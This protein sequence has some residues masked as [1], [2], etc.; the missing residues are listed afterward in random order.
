MADGALAGPCDPP[1]NEIV[2]EN[3]KPGNP[4]SE[5]DVEG[6]GDPSIQGFATE[7]SVDR[8][9][10]VHFKVDT[11]S[12]EY[13]LDVYRMGY[14]GG[15]G[16]RKVDTVEPS[17]ALPQKQPGCD[18]KPSTGLVDCGN[19]AESASWA[20]PADAVSGIYFAKL[21]REDQPSD[22]SQILFVV[23]DDGGG[24][25]LLFQT[26]DTTW[27][28]YNR[29][30]G[31][32]LYVGGPGANPGRAY[33]VS[34]NRPLTTRGTAPEDAP[35]SAEYPMVR[36][37]ER[38]GYDVS[39]FTGVDADRRG[40][41]ILDHEAYLSVGHDEYW[42]GAQRANVEAARDAGV[43]L[44]FF[45]GNEIFWK[46]RWED[47]IDG[48]GADHRTLV[49]YKETHANAKIDPEANVWTGTWRD[50]R[51]SP[52]ADGGKPENSLSGTIF[53]VD[54]GT[55]AI[56][57]P[58]ADGRLR[59]WRD[60]GIASLGPG[61]TA[62]LGED[63]LGYEWD[64]DVD[65]GF[66]PPGLMDLS[67]T[68]VEVP[69][70]LVDYGSN[71]APG[72]GTHHLTLYR[73]PNGA[74]VFGA[75]TVQWSWGLDG[76]HD[77]GNTKPDSRMQQ[78]TVNLLADMGV[79]AGSL[80]GGLFAAT[81]TTDADPP[82]SAIGSPGEGA[83]LESGE[84]VTIG[85][86]ATD[87]SGET[88]GGQ[89][90]GIEVS[91]DGGQHWHPADGRDQWTYAWT[92]GA[93]GK[94]T[95]EARA[96][97]DSG[98]LE[99]AGDQ[100]GVEVTPPTCPCSIWDE[101]LAAPEDDDPAGAVE[102]GVKFR[103]DVAGLI[104]GVRFYKTA[105]NVGQHVGRL[106]T[107][108]GA[109]LAQAAFTGESASGW[110]TV[111]FDQ[112]VSI[113]AGKTYIAS[114]HAPS[115]HY[116]GLS[117]YFALVGHDN[118]PLHALADG[119]DG[120]N[121]VFQYGPAGGLFTEGPPRSFHSTNYLVDVVFDEHVG[122]DTTP[123]SLNGQVPADGTTDIGVNVAA[124]A[125]FSEAMN[126]ATISSGTI[127]LRD[128][129]GGLVESAVS[130]SPGNRRAAVKSI[131]PLHYATTYTATVKGGAAGVK[132]LAGNALPSSSS[133]SFTT[134]VAP[135]PPPD[136][137]P[138]GPILVISNAANPFSRYYGEILRAEGLNEF[139][140]KDISTV[141][142]A[143]LDAY[144][145]AILGETTL[146]SGQAQMLE[147]WVGGGGNLIAM[148][149][150]PQLSGLLGLNP[151]GGAL[152]NA[153][154]KVD[155]GTAP[156][157]GIV[158]Q[159]IQFHG[160][161]DRYTPTSAQTI[162]TLYSS[163][164]S[165]T[166]NPAVTLRSVGGKGGQ[167]ASFS[168]DLARSVVL[169]RQGN[170]AWSGEER[171]GR[172]PIRSD[173][174]FFGNKAG[175]PQPD[176]VDLEKVAI[177]QADEQQRLL[178]NLIEKMNA[179]RK[180]LPRFWFLPRDE[181][182]AVV[183]T[184]DD[185]GN[186]GTAGRFDGYEKA[187]PPG[188]VVAK[189]ECVR[190]TSYIYPGTPLTDA[191]AS[192]YAS[193]GFE[194]SLHTLTNCGDWD[195]QGELNAFFSSQL[196]EFSANFPS[197]PAPATNRTHCV[198]WGDWATQPKVERANGIRL[199]ANYY[200][201]PA[202]W[203]Q[204][205]PGMFTGS[206]MPMRF[207]DLDGSL[208]D[209]YQ[210]ATQMTDESEQSYP[211]TA[212]TLLDNALG[213]KGYYGVF[214][215]N[216]HT[217]V[218]EIE[219]SDAIVASAQ[220]R[221]VPVVSARQMLTWLD[222]RNQSSFGSIGWTGN[223]LSFTISPGE[224]ANGLRAM[225]PVSPAAGDLLSV[226]R[227][228]TPV[229]T[230]IQTIKG[231]EYAFFDATAGSYTAVYGPEL[232][233]T[234]PASPANANS[235]K[236]TGSAPSG[237]TVR[238]YTT[239]D[240][241]GSPLAT[242]SAA[243]L[244]GGI[245]VSV[246][247]DT[248][249][250]FR[251]T[252]T[253]ANGSVSP[254]SAPLAYVEDSSAPDA[255][256]GSH[257]ANPVASAAASFAFS[258]SDGS[259]SGVASFQ[260]RRDSEAAGGWQ[261]C[262][263]PQAYTGLADG[264]H[265]FEVRAIDQAGNVDQSPAVFSWTVDTVAPQTQI[266]L[267][268]PALSATGNAE[269]KFS[270]AD[271][272]GSGVAS[273]QC[274]LDSS[275][276]SGWG[277]CT[278]PQV[279]SSLADGA[280]K[281]EVRAID[282]AGN[283]DQSPAVFSW[284]V[285]VAPPDTQIGK[286]PNA[287]VASSAAQF[288]FSG[289]DGSGSGV[290]SFQCRLDSSE[291]S[292]WGACTSPQVY[293]SLADGSHKFEVRAVD[294]AGNVDPTPALFSW[295][296]DM[297]APQT[298]TAGPPSLSASDNAQFEF[299][300][301]DG[302]GSGVSSFQCRLDSLEASAWGTCSSPKEYATLADGSHKFEVRAIDVVGNVDQSPA[303]LSWTVDTTAPQ[304]Q[305][306]N[307]PPLISASAAATLIFSGADGAGS[308]VASFE[309]RLDSTAPSGWQACASP[310]EY[311]ALADGV[312]KF[313][314]RAIDVAGN[315]DPS[316]A[317]VNWTVDTT[318]PDTQIDDHPAA[319][320]AT[321]SAQFAFSG[322]DG[323]GSGVAAFQCRLDSSQAG[324]W[325][326]C[327]SPKSYGGL[328]DGGHKLEVRAIDQAGNV[329]S[330]AA[331]FEWNVDTTAPQTQVDSGPPA[332]SALAVAKFAFSG[333]DGA[334]SGVASL[335]C[336]RD[337][338][339]P[340]GWGPC[341]SPLE[342]ASLGDGGHKFEVRA[343][344]MAGNVD[345]TPAVFNW[346]IDTTSPDT[347]IG[348]H[349]NALVASSAAQFEF[350]GSDGS[351]S[352]VASFQCRLDSSEASGWAS[353]SSPQSYVS[354]GDGSHEF[355]VRAIDQA[356]N[357]DAV[358]ASF[359]WSID[360]AAPETQI[361]TGPPALSASAKAKFN[362]SGADGAGS[363][364]ASFE[365]R[366]DSTAPSAW[367]ACTS[368]KEYAALADGSHKLEVRA[369]DQIGNVDLTPAV[370]NWTVDTTAPESQIDTHPSP[371]SASAEAKFTFSGSDA[372][373]SG[374]A[375]FECRRDSNEASAWEAC[376][377]PR[378]YAALPDG[379]HGLE[380][381]A[382]DVAGNVDPSPASFNWTIDTAAPDTQI[383]S[384]AKAL[385]GSAAA[386]FA[387]SGSDGTGSGV[388]SFQCR[389]DSTQAADWGGC[390]SPRAYG[391]LADG[392][393]KFEVR[394]IDAAGNVDQAPASFEWTVDTTP[395]QTQID[396][397]PP[398]LSGSAAAKFSFSG[399]DGSGSGVASFQCRLDSTAPSAWQACS[400]P[401]EYAA[402]ADGAH[403]LEVRAVDGAANPDPSPASF[404][405]T[406][407]TTPPAVTIDSLSRALLGIGQTSEV[408]WHANEN[409]AF[410]LR[411]GGNDCSS[412]T[413]LDSGAYGSQ[414]ATHASI[415]AVAD[416]AE[417]QNTLRLCLTDAASNRGSTTAT[418][419]RDTATPE[420]QIDSH[421]AALSASASA[422]FAFSGSDG[423][424]SGV[425]SFQ[426]RRDSSEASAWA[427]C[428][429][430]QSYAS[431]ADGTHSFEVRAVDVAGNPDPSPASF[432]WTVDTTPPSVAIDSG[433]HGLTND[434]TPSFAFHASEPGSSFECSIDSGTPDFG[435]CSD[436]GSHTPASPLT[437]GAHTFRVRA[438][439][440]ASNQG[441][442]TTREFTVDTAA[443]PAPELTLTV[444]ASPANENSPKIVGSAPAG[445]TV[446]IYASLDCSGTALATVT[447]AQLVD[448]VSVSVPDDSTTK[449]SANGTSLAGNPS[450]CSDPIAYAE[451]SSAPN[452]QI[453]GHPADPAS[454]NVATFVFSGSD[455]SGSGVASFQCRLDSTQAADWG[456]CSSPKSYSSLGD[457][458]HG[459][460][461]RAIDQAG[462]VDQSPASF[463]WTIDTAAPQTQID[464][465]PAAL[466]TSTSAQFEFSG[467]D[468]SGTGVAVFQCR[469]DSAEASAWEPCTSPRAY[470][471]LAD[472]GHGFEVRAVDGAGNVD[473]SPASFSWAVDTTGPQTQIDAHP[474]SLSP[475]T[476]AQFGFSATDPGGS[477]VSSFECRLDS[478][479]PSGWEA[480][481]S[482]VGYSSL[483][484]G[485][486]K[487]EVRAIDAAGNVDPSP[488]AFTW[489][490]DTTAPQTQIDAHPAALTASGSAQFGFSGSDSSGAT[491]FECRR[492]SAEPSAWAPC[493][494]P[495]DYSSL[496]DGSHKFEVRA[497]DAVGNVDPSTASFEWS[498]DTAAPETQIDSHPAALS[499][500][501]SASFAF[502]GSDGAGSGVGS[503]QCR[504]DSTEASAWGPC[505]SPQSYASL[506]DGA[507]VFQVRAIDLAGN[508]DP[509]PTAFGWT[510][511]TTPP[512]ATIDSGPSGLTNDSTPTF[513]FHAGEAGSSFECS[514]DSGAP[515]FGP[516]SDAGS[517]T[518]ASP[519]G[520]GVHTFRVRATDAAANQGTATIREFSVDTA[521]PS[522]P[523]LTS[524]VPASPANENSP[525]IVGSA[526]GGSTVRL[527]A[528]IDCSGPALATVSAAQLVDGVLVSVL[529]DTTTKFSANGTSL[530]GNPSG[531]S[532]PI[533]YAEDSSAPNAQIDGHPADPASSNVATF[534]FSGSDGSGS[535][536]A[537]FQ[538]RIDS[539]QAADWAACSSPESYG[540]LGEGAH[541]FE[542]RA[543]DRAGN[544]D[545]SPASFPW[546]IDTAAP[547][548]Q[549]DAHPAALTTSTSAQFEFS[550]SDGS[551][552]GVAIFQ[553]RRDSAEASAWEPC[554][555]PR[556]YASLADGPHGFEV[557]AVDG[558]G[559]VDP[560]PASF[561]WT[562]DT[563]G[564][565]TQI[566]AHPASLSPSTAAQF[567]FS[568][569][570]P[571]GSGVSS[572]EC[573]LDSTA[574]SGW[575]ACGSPVGYSSL[576]DGPHKFEV[577]AID[578]A[579]NVDPS[580][581]AFTWTVDTT[582]PQTQIDAHPAALTASGSA[583]FGFSGSDSSGATSFEC[584]RDSAEPSAWAPCS[585][586]KDY[587]SLAD[588]SHKFEVR[589]IDAV[590]NV[591]PS[592]A[593]FE[594]SVDTAAPET[595]IDSHPAALSA[596]ASASFAFSGSDGAGSGVGSFQCRRDSTEASAWGPCASPQSYASLGD[597]AHVFQVRAID[598][599]GNADPSPTA[600]GWTI[601]TTPPTA[602]IDSG[603][604]GLTN[605]STPTFAFHAGEA[606]SSFECSIDSGAPSFG[607]CSDAGSHTPASPLGDG[608]HTFRVR[609]TDAA[610][611][612][613]TATI[614]EFSVDTAAP[615][616]P[617]LTSTVPA[618]PANENS[619]KIVGSA[620]GGSTVRLYAGIDCS[621]PALATVSAAQLV[622]GV[623]VSVL[624]DTT[625]KFSA[626][627]TSLAGNPSGCSDP[628]A[629]AE[630]SS[631]P[632]AQ[633][634]GHPADP[635][636]SNVA[637]F[638]FSG[639]DGSGSGVASFQC[640]IDSGQAADWAAC[641]SPES[642]GSLG[643]GAHS[644]EVRA[645]DRAG[646]VDQSPAS[647]AWT[648][649]TV[650]PQT[651]ID[652][653]PPALT[654]S[655]SAQFEFSGSDGSGTGVAI[656]QCRRD[657]AEASAWEPCTSPRAY[658]SLADG[659]HGF[660]VRAVDGAGN[661]DPSP[662]S[663]GWT[664]DTTAPPSPELTGTVP[665]SP[666]NENSPKIVGS[667]PLGSTVRLYAN[668]DCSGAAIATAS[669]AELT[670]GVAVSVTDDSTSHFS[671]DAIASGKPSPCS[672]P[673][674]YVED[675]TAPSTQIDAHPDALSG[676]TTAQFAFSGSDGSGSGVA[677]FEC[678]RD[679]ESAA[680]WQ[681]CNSP[682]SYAAL[683]D[684]PH[685][686]QVRAIDAAGN[687]DSS[688]AV[689]G[690]TVD[691]AP[692]LVQP[693]VTAVSPEPPTSAHDVVR[694]L[695]I[696]YDRRRRAAILTIEVPGPGRLSAATPEPPVSSGLRKADGSAARQRAAHQI[697][698]KSVRT[699]KA[700]KVKLRVR[701]TPAS[702]QL[703]TEE[704]KVTI[705]VLVSFDANDGSS[706]SR[707]IA[708]ALK[709]P[710][711]RK[712]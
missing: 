425:A 79:K 543:I 510:I 119:V 42:S 580:P 233:A 44:A 706:E 686:F 454:S 346:T 460:E 136:S 680:A 299:S 522:P 267:G 527:Y 133:W 14:Y 490:V 651:Q 345:L 5:W 74:L 711:P 10:T 356:G 357:V 49:A 544:V 109:Q 517:H 381:R 703:L 524:T 366:L 216:M 11:A 293:S 653:H 142:A 245:A 530:A 152:A 373:G 654:T 457:G 560:S 92:P 413:V 234:T 657:S 455:G 213:S 694:I 451:D 298:Q 270:G 162:A 111:T 224:G 32:S 314:V 477:G 141:T 417:G 639:S 220:A 146:S 688:P 582:A 520:D 682:Q 615:S 7:I 70:R 113:E 196:G 289:S 37:L 297:T 274:R 448:G 449:F 499:A 529:D 316:P 650:A 422:S 12:D 61:E 586:P 106:W 645:I 619:P 251:A 150:D 598:L 331:S 697:V 321:P 322:A 242:G 207:A 9:E 76:E 73:A 565:Q 200:Y 328:A 674:A 246:P 602:T 266:D 386:S 534:V 271:A 557:R 664:V 115:G 472:G 264:A 618:S 291:A 603:P 84:A 610:A 668:A 695:Q 599:A 288:E 675:S 118:G 81:Q 161:A 77:R 532:D 666:A 26:S 584:R 376:A 205:R 649:D 78:A 189:W 426:C 127:E 45:S 660:E 493:S 265:K 228:G 51:F 59:L 430:P 613:G 231:I 66:R 587:S 170:P 712:Q 605:D 504:R 135:P 441:A 140:V 102:L 281:F 327:S 436:A 600:F 698:P 16:A 363:G 181:R 130:Y 188:C 630:D 285:D 681:P 601:D 663:F 2:C 661:V 466:T 498:V 631:A 480:C 330:T 305:I 406:V 72:T 122:P 468:G 307:G 581:A 283:V 555:S 562:V 315:A 243:Q 513:A 463:P 120:E 536:V 193:A 383:D 303:S 701:L 515:S 63:T 54:E 537:S 432:S 597:G 192:A 191:Q 483:V 579:G 22:G 635:A 83:Q 203:V 93:V 707:T 632:N 64:E 535:G 82:T 206:G 230:A 21:V 393:H 634:D 96:V 99:S 606:G 574:P 335:E 39:Y 107:A 583:Q 199:D 209:V 423:P 179:D 104:A 485:P 416:L 519:L 672:Q 533:A 641:S 403:K 440:A 222:G 128:G 676:S 190:S 447:P 456:P 158:D 365:C 412:G 55:A 325:A 575:E 304:T 487:F 592:T 48:S 542:V 20:V 548:T 502:S 223:R 563:T 35:F 506:G 614:R 250:E 550:G 337:S 491:S 318:A 272:T 443:P 671:A 105:G 323:S 439:D 25:D 235:L 257:P 387:F 269:F 514:I 566:D 690:W 442:S 608:V 444:P 89:V 88:A 372:G 157:A 474:A 344:D 593:S 400:S 685:A 178:T 204:D 156:G 402:L 185:H 148:R 348:K 604:S 308:G 360:T 488:A 262:T 679:S 626:N 23:R 211:F 326:P 137:G 391:S 374:L 147:S 168:Y 40:S 396:S 431:L 217:D 163:A 134:E 665:A 149:P 540:S 90:A 569:T 553:C 475:S 438:T 355:E 655:T 34:Y 296:V 561:G 633:I 492:D 647:F 4:P 29:Y 195:G 411:V 320:L 446:R 347:Q 705:R 214:G 343:I 160:S 567:G 260:C 424:G 495:K 494:S 198:A 112:P 481:G 467:S 241:S 709:Q 98:N 68:T 46:T 570:D 398:A 450:G 103:S 692:P 341:L 240:C 237:S 380:V 541:S 658:A 496:A 401:K 167:A 28:A 312:H 248:T 367:Q 358:P 294:V 124:A 286:H 670:S 125:T 349:P 578:A 435:P 696:K 371:L 623:L 212:D 324:D 571:G 389:L 677:S 484:D 612:Q 41:E 151:S 620:P 159:T 236:V 643:E 521:A 538:C 362:F 646:N 638:V 568:A 276:A 453:D 710:L 292:G 300:G 539:G 268:P 420:T 683:A 317:V 87:A 329:D 415:V 354:L 18:T 434:S 210:V 60:T 708:I 497:I 656:F 564:P 138:G 218:A 518:P 691:T 678:R 131:G 302:S 429:S 342:Y 97:D 165:A 588:G 38:N 186:G 699:T 175:D 622:D 667:A 255:Q 91:T 244:A 67:S 284:N 180:P 3:S 253:L 143:T 629:Y 174:L 554:T 277:A 445:S 114:Y 628:I 287:L 392:F 388:A 652:A 50:P 144:D 624:D 404:S 263:S 226:K 659:P 338:G 239:A 249:A 427:P 75:G 229:A 545:Q 409:G 215:A 310:K 461:V 187:S 558:A 169:T 395:P 254:C 258:G 80:Q 700:G 301:S 280:H 385:E 278:S 1:A 47:G 53:M 471:S 433:P 166:A 394:A 673:L 27:E 8:G 551:G 309:C 476:A 384:H 375:S 197:L 627:G 585:S 164:S 511:D 183:M 547:Q 473:P 407:D 531:C 273:F 621:G 110:Q 176:W 516:C 117:D 65:N 24:S 428:S 85:G 458:T 279:Y 414:P 252:A 139:T 662:A 17:A 62:T 617:Q 410:E 704:H 421:P 221:G 489:T 359:E 56:R 336:R 86:T 636:S 478:T 611:N 94:V 352:G 145:V 116:A 295:N 184:G 379:S 261:A 333:T 546:T 687:A 202:A 500:S 573:R 31:N 121:G 399:S 194:L 33:E 459:F 556:A 247:D 126:P 340:S 256:I 129:S 208:V 596:S 368:P 508:A 155:T 319:L 625:T 648:I 452:A 572:F 123:P 486:H 590:G 607:P 377:S 526:P 684:G 71:Y 30:G 238:I 364:V 419:S 549:I 227:S 693:T 552:T 595:Q 225:L 689:Y 501:A 482:P 591:D 378:T 589:A 418:L 640:R 101:A 702:R 437:D 36:W 219:D 232:I 13:R 479:A 405:W 642:Y 172:S 397:G 470:A 58:A 361:E 369:I 154:M 95:I 507:H 512:T 259:G 182:A 465:H 390:A 334:G 132:D 577:R 6:A 637:T 282:Q 503:F 52:P 313:E 505:A 177:P 644:F 669:D 153:Y 57:V 339:E 108:G 525:K 559:N 469:R 43:D 528:G 171:D 509:S 173:D 464:A 275:E 616:P 100:V 311:A 69:Q 576:V 353:C 19:W 332:L 201:W 609:A 351:G 306:G 370:L 408:H 594:W 462:N 350:S 382:I 523:Q 15:D 290:S